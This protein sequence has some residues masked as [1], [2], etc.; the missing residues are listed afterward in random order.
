M[1]KDY[2]QAV[3]FYTAAC[4]WSPNSKVW[5]LDRGTN[6]EGEYKCINALRLTK[7]R[8]G[9]KYIHNGYLEMNE[10]N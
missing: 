8:M 7:F 1:N 5:S 10:E 6:I 9:V 4:E 3:K 2:L